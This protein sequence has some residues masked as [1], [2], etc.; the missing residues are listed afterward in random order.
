MIPLSASQIHFE[1]T[2][3]RAKWYWF[4]YKLTEFNIFLQI[5]FES[6]TYSAHGLWI[7]YTFADSLWIP[8][9]FR[10]FTINSLF[11]PRTTDD[12]IICVTNLLWIY[13]FFANSLFIPLF[14]PWNKILSVV[15]KQ[16]ITR[17]IFAHS[18]FKHLLIFCGRK[19]NQ[20]SNQVC[21]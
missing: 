3:Y 10:E 4:H 16:L 6:P 21:F 15:H 19:K 17:G 2:V 5:H 8:F 20:T 1:S 18:T 13:Y 12:S 9:L 11:I 7:H 14:I